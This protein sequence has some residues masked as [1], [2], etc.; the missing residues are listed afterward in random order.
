LHVGRR[1]PK[2]ES[3]T[4]HRPLVSMASC[5]GASASKAFSTP[6]L[7]WLPINLCLPSGEGFTC[8]ALTP[9]DTPRARNLLN[10]AVSVDRAWPHD[11]PLSEDG[12]EHYFCSHASFGVSLD[13]SGG[14]LVGVFYVK[15][16]FPG[17]SDHVCNGG[18]VVAPEA[19]QRGVGRA[20][21]NLFFR[22]SRDLRYRAVLFN[23]VFADN[24]AS[25]ALWKSVGME[26]IG[27]VPAVARM[28]KG[29]G[30]SAGR[31]ADEGTRDEDEFD[32]IDAHI[33]YKSLL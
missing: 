4:P 13:G 23:L 5:Y 32:F 17:R 7:P 10:H 14:E 9:D 25:L 24:V 19:R 29:G 2:L 27:T 26:R 11:A 30:G 18:F 1:P 3:T 20:M 33:L 28:R 8:R 12:F 31:T 6:S 16:N 15:P 22:I 21:A